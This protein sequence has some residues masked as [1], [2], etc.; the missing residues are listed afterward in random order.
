M[1]VLAKPIFYIQQVRKPPM[2][3]GLKEAVVGAVWVSGGRKSK[4]LS[5]KVIR[6]LEEQER[7]QGGWVDE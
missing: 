7:K 6:V 4:V 1:N 2:S 5:G 3:R